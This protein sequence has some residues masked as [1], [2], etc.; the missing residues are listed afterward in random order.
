M[1]PVNELAFL[2]GKSLINKVIQGLK[3][4]INLKET[5]TI[6]NDMLQKT[7]SFV[8]SFNEQKN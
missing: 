2:G 8:N 1:R 4:S 3:L 6:Y 7:Q 5:R